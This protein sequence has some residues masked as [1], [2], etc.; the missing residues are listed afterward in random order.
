MTEKR[1]R[2]ALELLEYRKDFQPDEG[3]SYEEARAQCE[4]TKTIILALNKQKPIPVKRGW[5]NLS[6][7]CP[8][9]NARCL[10]VDNYCCKCG[11]KLDWRKRD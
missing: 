2:L 10:I 11:Q 6:Y 1:V 4:L 3:V 8:V 5:S 9:C 7:R